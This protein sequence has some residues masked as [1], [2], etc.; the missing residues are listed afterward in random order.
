MLCLIA[1]RLDWYWHSFEDQKPQ[2]EEGHDSKVYWVR[3]IVTFEH[4][5]GY[6]EILP[7]YNILVLYNNRYFPFFKIFLDFKSIVK[8]S[9]FLSVFWNVLRHTYVADVQVLVSQFLL[10]SDTEPGSLQ[11]QGISA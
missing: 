6:N 5:K 7:A 11:L 3:T 1:Q 2:I 8:D 10:A 4:L 9:L